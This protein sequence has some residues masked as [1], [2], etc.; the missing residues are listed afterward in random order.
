MKLINKSTL[1]HTLYAVAMAFFLVSCGGSDKEK[2]TDSTD[3]ASV[4]KDETAN[5]TEKTEESPEE[6]AKKDFEEN[7]L[8]K[9]PQIV[10]NLVRKWKEISFEHKDGKVENVEKENDYLIFKKDGT[11][12]E[13]FHTDKKIEA[14]RWRLVKEGKVVH[15][16][17]TEHRVMQ[18]VERDIVELTADKFVWLDNIKKKSTFKAVAEEKTEGGNEKPVEK[19]EEKPVE[20]KN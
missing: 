9:Y 3:T 10:D 7:T 20:K 13:Y 14:G 18:D 4:S 11:F 1:K 16:T 19:T 6:K 2:S 8:K 15:L 12:E 5:N 17:S